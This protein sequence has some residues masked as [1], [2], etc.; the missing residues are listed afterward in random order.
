MKKSLF[1]VAAA[2]VVL[3]S[4][5][6]DVKIDENVAL[7]GSNAQKEIAFS[8]YAQKTHR[9][10][11]N[12]PIEGTTFTP[13][14]MQVVAYD[15]T[16]AANYF[17]ATTFT[18]DEDTW[19]GAKYWPFAPATINFLA[20]A[21]LE[22]TATWNATNPASA[23]SLA[24]GDNSSAQKDLMYACGTGTVTQ[25]S[26]A[27]VFPTNVPMTFQHAQAWVIF[28][29]KAGDA[30]SA[31]AITVNSITLNEVSCQGTF[32]VTHS[33]WNKTKAER[34]AAQPEHSLD[35]TV[36]GDWSSFDNDNDTIVAAH[37]GAYSLSTS[38]ADTASLMVVP[39]KGMQSFTIN[40]TVDGNTYNYTYTPASAALAQA[41][42][43]TYNITLTLHEIEI[44]PTV[45]N[46]TEGGPTNI[47][48]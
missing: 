48:L 24:M 6:S 27:L 37:D 19:K 32:A 1:F 43:Y 18:K 21:E 30:T 11:S 33:N 14:T 25:N 17:D 45:S 29:V 2:A 28:A 40:Y 13:N 46:W 16:A 7:E 44:A 34:E 8:A 4:C 42:K 41:T 9:V 31:S 12:A 35:G 36:S 26:N 3:A 15:A 20:Y 47:D 10:R 38:V 39:N 22:G 5:S 23:V